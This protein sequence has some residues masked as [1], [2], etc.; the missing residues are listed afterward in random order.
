MGTEPDRLEVS[1]NNIESRFEVRSKEN[2]AF[3]QYE[4]SGN[5]INIL[6][7]EVPRALEGKGLGGRLARAA[8]EFARESGLK[9]VPF[10]SFVGGYIRKHP[11]YLPLVDPLHQGGLEEG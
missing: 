3:L 7:T 4:V 8:L 1:Q 10:C 2:V 6:H 11:E 9:V 5:S